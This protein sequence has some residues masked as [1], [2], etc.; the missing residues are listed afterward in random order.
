MVAGQQDLRHTTDRFMGVLE[1]SSTHAGKDQVKRWEEI[2]S[3]VLLPFDG[4][5]RHDRAYLTLQ[6]FGTFLN[7]CNVG[8]AVSFRRFIHVRIKNA[9]F[10]AKI[11]LLPAFKALLFG[12]YPKR[13]R[14]VSLLHRVELFFFACSYW[15]TSS[16]SSRM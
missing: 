7:H 4:R 9:T 12:T 1:G 16:A 8:I 15:R 3:S 13:R 14:S 6:C 2:L 5:L 10:G 11:T